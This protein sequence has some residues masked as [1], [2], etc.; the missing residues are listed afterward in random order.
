MQLAFL[1]S[2]VI[3]LVVIVLVTMLPNRAAVDPNADLDAEL[4]ELED[5]VEELSPGTAS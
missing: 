5:D 3:A 1:V 4:A 2:A